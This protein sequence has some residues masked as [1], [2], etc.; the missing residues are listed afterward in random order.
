MLLQTLAHQV[1]ANPYK[2]IL[3][4]CFYSYFNSITKAL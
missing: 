2:L 4:V 1:A 3:I